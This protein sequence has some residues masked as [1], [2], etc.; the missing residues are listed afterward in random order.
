MIALAH[1]VDVLIKYLTAHT[2]QPGVFDSG[3]WGP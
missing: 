1:L 3:S 2:P